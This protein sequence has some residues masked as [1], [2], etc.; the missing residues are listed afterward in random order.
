VH[1]GLCTFP[2]EYS[3]SPAELARAAEERGFESL[4]VAEHSH[5]PASRRTPFPAGG[6]LPRIYYEV[7][8]PFVALATAASVTT[9]LKLATGVCLLVQRDAI[10]TA[11]MVASLDQLSQG[12]F[13]FGVGAGWNAEEIE[14]HGTPFARRG[15]VLRERI[16]AMKR[17]WTDERAEYHG[18]FVRLEPSFAWPKPRQKP[19]PPIHVG[20]GWPAGAKRAVQ[21][22]DGWIPVGIPD[23]AAAKLPE[24]RR[25]AEAAGRDPARLEV[26]IYY[27]PA[28][29]PAL[30]R[31]RDAG[32]A[33][34]VFGVPSE[35]AE[36]VLP[37]LD[38][39]A[40]TAR[41][42]G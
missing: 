5:I 11:K 28:D 10:Q 32:I 16:E 22:G 3:I 33:R 38:R 41:E 24:L 12:R 15:T 34:V 27:A 8:D 6:D 25:M 21:W 40:A 7:M 17:L 39:L 29:V 26:S 4:W 9:T 23:V 35:P 14:Q 19:W 2:T 1:Y 18:E 36:K 42:V 13:L 30:V 20:G 31:L 37:L